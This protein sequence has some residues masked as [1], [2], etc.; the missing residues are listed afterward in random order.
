MLL[1]ITDGGVRP[2]GSPN[3][4]FYC[5]EPKGAPHK[6]GCVIPKRT[7]VLE[8]KIQYVVSVPVDWNTELIE[9]QRNDGSWCSVNDVRLIAEQAAAAPKNH[10][11]T[12]ART[13]FRFVREATAEDMEEMGYNGQV[14]AEAEREDQCQKQ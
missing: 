3:K 5:H 4:C 7:V 8:M 2:A 9:F 14:K 11:N 1:P 10:C 6:K 13:S 12:C